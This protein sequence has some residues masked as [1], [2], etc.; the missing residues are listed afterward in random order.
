MSTCLPRILILTFAFCLGLSA[1]EAPIP[2]TQEVP[3]HRMEKGFKPEIIATRVDTPPKIDGFL[4][5][6]VWRTAPSSG[7]LIQNSPY[8][9]EPML[10]PSEFR[11]AYD[12]NFIYV[13]LWHWDSEPDKIVARLMRRDDSLR[14]DDYSIVVLDT[15]N[16]ERNSYW[17]RINPNGTRQDGITSNNR[18]INTQWDGIWDAKTQVTE[19]GWFAELA[20][21]LTTFSFDPQSDTWGLNVTRNIKRN[22]Q[23]GIWSSP[24]RSMRSYYVSEA[25]KLKGLSGLKQGLGLEFN[26]YILGKYSDDKVLGKDD[27]E[28][29]WGGDF[30]YRITPKMSATVSYNTDFAAAETDARQVNLTRFSL[31]FPEKRRFFLED[32]GVFNFGGLGGRF[33][34]RSRTTPVFLP[35][36]SRRIGLSSKGQVVPLVGAAKLTGRVGEFDIGII[37][38]V[39]DDTDTLDSKNAFVGRVSRQVLEQSSLGVLATH[40]DPNSEYDN[41][42]LGS[43]FRFLTNNFLSRYRLEANVFVL[44]TKSDD[45]R[46]S[47][48]L[49]PSFGGNVVIP[50]DNF[51]V[52]GAFL[53]IDDDFNPALGFAP[54]RGIRRFFT[55]A[56]YQPQPQSIPWL[57]RYYL[58]YEGE[59]VT[60]LS[61]N[62]QSETHTLTPAGLL[63]E[64]AEYLEFSLEHSSDVPS[65]E[66]EISEGVVIPADDYS[67]T[68][69]VVVLET[70]T[71][72]SVSFTHELSFGDFYDG[73]RVENSSEITWAPSKHFA[74]IVGHTKQSVEL[75]QGDFDIKLASLTALINF[76]PDF[77][78]SNLVQY[79]NISDS[80]GINSRLIWEYKPG[81]KVFLVL[82]QS[83]LDETTGFVRQ[84]SDTTI[85]LSSIFRF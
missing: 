42:L 50:T 35:Y 22:D 26:P 70:A 52:E 40:G 2:E 10:Q 72:R 17:F 80:M 73:T 82:N 15:F 65:E 57:R 34:R 56:T 76:T 59:V 53:Q 58:S 23:R 31:F 38:A 51:E 9:G 32:S 20:F 39:L 79:D 69:G 30:R 64:S 49:S 27:F 43:D 48:S 85:K 33:R 21:P 61:G 55:N 63:F 7:P 18:N 44:G 75:P 37:D 68:R 67:W 45:P 29:D 16:D 25:G 41:L 83:Y 28:F 46:F 78:W 5:E 84:Q 36:F 12:D 77:T 8:S 14:P 6:E 3:E 11:V 1:W 13:A 4:D 19:Y 24:R 81:A 60:D 47:D 54:R 66:F 62:L 71:K 74:S